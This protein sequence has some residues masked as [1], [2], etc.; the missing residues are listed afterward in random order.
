M[1]SS[2]LEDQNQHHMS[3][4]FWFKQKLSIYENLSKDD[5]DNVKSFGANTGWFRKFMKRYNFY[6]IKMG[7]LFLLTLWLLKTFFCIKIQI[8]THIHKHTH[9]LHIYVYNTGTG[10]LCAG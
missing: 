10:I 1:L 7:K 4:S 9:N 3:V 2:W 6:N 5:N 8:Y